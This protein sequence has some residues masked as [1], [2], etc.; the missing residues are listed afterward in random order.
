MLDRK[1][2]GYLPPVLQ[3]VMDFAAITDALQ[4]EVEAAWEALN[5]V[6][7]NQFIDTATEAGVAIW[8]KELGIVP[9]ATDTLVNRKQ[10]LN[11]AWI[12][13]IVYTYRQLSAWLVTISEK[14]TSELNGY[15]LSVRIPSVLDYKDVISRIQ[16]RVPANILIK[17]IITLKQSSVNCYTG[18]AIKVFT[19]N[20]AK[21]PA[22]D[23]SGIN[24]LSDENG[25]ILVEDAGNQILFEEV[26]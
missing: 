3:S 6:M 19:Q 23:M 21:S 17:P 25:D 14:S 5:L 2:I 12:C 9:L 15:T 18:G 8:E 4:P 13:G 11:N 16:F 10:R 24:L 1:L 22:W 7:N 26:L 20:Q